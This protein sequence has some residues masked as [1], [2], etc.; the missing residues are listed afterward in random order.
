MGELPIERAEWF[1][2]PSRSRGGGRQERFAV[3]VTAAG[4]VSGWGDFPRWGLPDLPVDSARLDGMLIGRDALD[5]GG[6]WDEMEAAGIPYLTMAAVDVSLWDLAG[7]ITGRPV[8]D[9]VGRVR[10]RARVYVHTPFNLAP[11]EYA[12]HAVAWRD[13][14]FHGCKIHPTLKRKGPRRGDPEADLAIFRAV[15]EAVGGD[16]HYMLATDNFSTYDFPTALRVGRVVEDLGFAWFESPMPE[17]EEWIEPHARLCRELRVPVCGPEHAPGGYR[18]RIHWIEAGACD[19]CRTESYH[20][21]FTPMLRLA[22]ACDDA[23]IPLEL[24]TFGEFYHLPLLGCTSESLVCYL[25][26]GTL[27]RPAADGSAVLMPESSRRCGVICP[28]GRLTPEP[29]TGADGCVAIP[30]VPGMGIEMD[31]EYVERYP[32]CG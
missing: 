2:Y 9:L 12:A 22:A 7:R 28:P 17:T 15:A 29:A 10:D 1:A 32:L 6:R 14:G 4:G 5:V 19:I 30:E 18:A 23:G 25:E 11:E 27:R 24:H 20:G 26:S 3:R 21:G 16:P 31:W 13:E 8:S